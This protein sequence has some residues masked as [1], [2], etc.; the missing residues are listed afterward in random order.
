M[1]N[2]LIV[3]LDRGWSKW[4]WLCPRHIKAAKAKGWETMEKRKPPHDLPCDACKAEPP[5]DTGELEGRL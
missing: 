5:G 4:E 1:G 3:R 2:V